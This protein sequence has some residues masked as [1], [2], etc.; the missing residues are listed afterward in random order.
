MVNVFIVL[1]PFVF[2]MD[3][4]T[5]KWS[6]FLPVSEVIIDCFFTKTKTKRDDKN[7]LLTKKM[8]VPGQKQAH[9]K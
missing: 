8:P 1:P 4:H 6:S 2:S 3:Y 9:N 7:R 5:K